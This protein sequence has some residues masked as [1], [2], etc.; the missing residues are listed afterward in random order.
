MTAVCSAAGVGG[1]NRS[2]AEMMKIEL[3]NTQSNRLI[4]TAACSAAHKSKGEN[5]K[6]RAEV[7]KIEL[8]YTQND[9]LV[10]TAVCSAT[11]IEGGNRS[12]AEMMKIELINTQSNRPIRTAACSAAHKS[13]GENHKN[14]AGVIKIELLTP[15]Q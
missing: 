3:V 8:P 15:E 11:G 1:G 5:H 10:V 2:S 4:R 9:R 13:K 7:M 14:R 6:D 12:S